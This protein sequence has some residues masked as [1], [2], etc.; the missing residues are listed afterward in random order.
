MVVYTLTVRPF[1]DTV[2]QCYR[3]VITVNTAPTGPL[4]TI[5]KRIHAPK[6]SPFT[7]KSICCPQDNCWQ[8][9]MDIN[10]P[11][12][13]MCVDSVGELFSFLTENGYTIDTSLTKMMMESDVRLS[14]SLL[15]MISF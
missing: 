10:N 5:T 4:S 1:Y 2:K 11:V 9:I 12:E 8:I 6:L 7:E 15:C 13:Y 14:N 3:K